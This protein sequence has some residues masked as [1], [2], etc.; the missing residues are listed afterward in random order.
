M[1]TLPPVWV[2][3]IDPLKMYIEPGTLGFV[4]TILVV[5]AGAPPLVL[6]RGR[7]ASAAAGCARAGCVLLR[8]R[9][10]AADGSA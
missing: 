1:N 8:A 5:L 6:A 4:A 9:L 10:P 3:R 7:L 2:W